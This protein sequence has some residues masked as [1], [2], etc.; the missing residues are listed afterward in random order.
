MPLEKLQMIAT[1]VAS[2]P[3]KIKWLK[4]WNSGLHTLEA[5]PAKGFIDKELE[6]WLNRASFWAGIRDLFL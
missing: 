1:I 2:P 6:S 4:N 5:F 3:H